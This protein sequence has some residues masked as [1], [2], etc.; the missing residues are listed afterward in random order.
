MII[1]FRY[2]N[3]SPKGSSW[4]LRWR[5]ESRPK[6]TAY[7]SLSFEFHSVSLDAIPCFLI[8]RPLYCLQTRHLRGI[9]LLVNNFEWLLIRPDRPLCMWTEAS[10]W[11]TWCTSLETPL[12]DKQAHAT[13]LIALRRGT[14]CFGNPRND[15][16]LGKIS[17]LL[18]LFVLKL[19]SKVPLSIDYHRPWERT[20]AFEAFW[21]HW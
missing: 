1:Y 16:D 13:S 3:G 10:Y 15:T 5:S 9:L 12:I 21:H 2:D 18:A 11:R 7:S 17:T 20:C 6:S 19:E 14:S 8:G 4:R